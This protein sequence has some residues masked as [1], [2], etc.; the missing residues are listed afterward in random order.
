[1]KRLVRVLLLAAAALMLLRVG[2]I[3]RA[4]GPPQ[5][6][7]GIHDCIAAGY[8]GT[9]WPCNCCSNWSTAIEYASNCEPGGGCNK[10]D[11]SRFAA[12]TDCGSV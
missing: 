5:P 8:T 2:P 12:S 3:T 1:M 10:G 7:Q 4:Q 9:M 11:Q 6:F